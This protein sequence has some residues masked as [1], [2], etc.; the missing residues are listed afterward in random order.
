MNFYVTDEVVAVE[1]LAISNEFKFER[2]HTIASILKNKKNII[3]T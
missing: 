1:A 3:V 2:M